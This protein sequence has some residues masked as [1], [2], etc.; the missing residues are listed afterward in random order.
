MNMKQFVLFFF[1]FLTHFLFAQEQD[2]DTVFIYEDSTNSLKLIELPPMRF[3]K[4]P[5]DRSQQ[6]DSILLILEST[7]IGD[8]RTPQ[9]KAS[10]LEN[11]WD[12]DQ[13]IR[14]A[15]LFYHTTYGYGSQEHDSIVK[16]MF[17]VDRFL[18]NQVVSYLEHHSH[19]D[20]ELRKTAC[21]TPCLVFHHVPGNKNDIELKKKYF[22]QF[23]ISY[24]KGNL[25]S[26]ELW[27][28]LFRLYQQITLSEYA[29]R[30]LGEEDQ[31]EDMINLLNLRRK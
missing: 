23:Y 9:D 25:S 17:E 5:V 2:R 20:I 22:P 4:P 19:P 13:G 6:K 8:L 21:S 26:G 11:I 31:I 1:F 3:S 16:R 14:N 12:A 18:F 29:D 10:F 27:M 28:Y 15:E 24:Q 30:E 7:D